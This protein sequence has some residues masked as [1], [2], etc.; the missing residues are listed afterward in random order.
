[1]TALALSSRISA[2][3]GCTDCELAQKDAVG[4]EEDYGYGSSDHEFF[5]PRT[6][7]GTLKSFRM[8]APIFQ[9]RGVWR[10]SQTFATP[11]QD[12]GFSV[13][14]ESRMF[15]SDIRFFRFDPCVQV[16]T[17]MQHATRQL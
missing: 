16:G 8:S 14:V 5:S 11:P 9:R 4:Q 17:C 12:Y 1:M 10:C 15:R 6:R 2:V 3:W 13:E 7:G